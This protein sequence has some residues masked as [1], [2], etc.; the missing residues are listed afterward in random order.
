MYQSLFYRVA[1]HGPNPRATGHAL[2][3]SANISPRET[4]TFS[5]QNNKG[6]NH[7]S[8]AAHLLFI[9]QRRLTTP[10]HSCPAGLRE[11]SG[12]VRGFSRPDRSFV[13]GCARVV[14][15]AAT[16]GHMPVHLVLCWFLPPSPF[17]PISYMKRHTYQ[18]SH[19]LVLCCLISVFELSNVEL[20]SVLRSGSKK[21]VTLKLTGERWREILADIKTAKSACKDDILLVQNAFNPL[22]P[23]RL[24]LQTTFA[25]ALNPPQISCMAKIDNSDW[26]SAIRFSLWRF[27]IA[28]MPL[29]LNL[30]P[31]LKALVSGEPC[32]PSA[33]DGAGSG[34]Y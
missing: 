7:W 10:C 31:L 27:E 30:T 25:A 22:C 34:K 3:T 21:R 1:A 29:L 8:L 13:P 32:H 6:R 5:F 4:K 17:Y 23:P 9:R 16:Q 11:A 24:H 2:S 19:W 28:D 12:K 18:L 26:N 33:C 20:L 14:I 15:T